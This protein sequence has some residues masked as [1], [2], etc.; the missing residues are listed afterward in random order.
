MLGMVEG[1]RQPGRPTRR[2]IDDVLIRCDKDIKAAVMM[3]KTTGEDLCLYGPR[4]YEILRREE[5]YVN[6]GNV[7]VSL[8]FIDY[9]TF[10]H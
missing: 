2:W 9:G 7:T 4:D 10:S 3:T 5:E 6:Y 8:W 1:Q